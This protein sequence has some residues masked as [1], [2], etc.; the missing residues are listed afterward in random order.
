MREVACF[1]AFHHHLCR[2]PLPLSLS[3]STELH[4]PCDSFVLN[5]LFFF[6][7]VCVFCYSHKCLSC[8]VTI[9][10]LNLSKCSHF[11]L[12]VIALLFA[13]I[14]I[15]SHRFCVCSLFFHSLA[16][17]FTLASQSLLNG[18]DLNGNERI[19]N[20]NNYR[21]YICDFIGDEKARTNSDKR[22]VAT[23]NGI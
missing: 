14:P 16:L 18:N 23:V 1:F 17:F 13:F 4:F 2:S 5:G 20:G 19:V 8:I 6:R 22:F 12:I 9:N 15:N 21:I 3:L 7:C 10:P 11:H